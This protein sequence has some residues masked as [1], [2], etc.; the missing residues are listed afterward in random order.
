[1]NGPP[2]SRVLG[3]R[4]IAFALLLIVPGMFATNIVVARAVGDHVP[5][6]ALAFWRWAGVFVL[7]A[8][9]TIGPLWQARTQ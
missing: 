2:S 5:P 1:M 3:E 9:V 8:P 7:L 4:E 6:I